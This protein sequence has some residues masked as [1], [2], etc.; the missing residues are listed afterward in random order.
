MAA[1]SRRVRNQFQ[2]E[3]GLELVSIGFSAPCETV[4]RPRLALVPDFSRRLE[5][6][7]RY[8]GTLTWPIIQSRKVRGT[9]LKRSVA[10][11]RFVLHAT[12]VNAS[13]N[14]AGTRIVVAPK[15]A[16]ILEP[17]YAPVLDEPVVS[18]AGKSNTPRAVSRPNV[19]YNIVSLKKKVPKQRIFF[20][21]F[22]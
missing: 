7:L 2:D 6:R 22:T 14:E 19:I 17:L 3:T 4:P 9:V 10:I 1:S 20:A 21:L 18:R 8:E 15:A 5:R 12:F 16:R 13:T 11:S